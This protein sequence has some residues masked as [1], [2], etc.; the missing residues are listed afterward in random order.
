MCVCACARAHMYLH[1]ALYSLQT[2]CTHIIGGEAESHSSVYSVKMYSA[3]EYIGQALRK[4]LDVERNRPQPCPRA[5]GERR[6]GLHLRGSRARVS[7][8]VLLG[9]RHLSWALWDLHT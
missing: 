6:Q 7:G 9:R 5:P 1:I 3:P 4:V 8:W 2:P